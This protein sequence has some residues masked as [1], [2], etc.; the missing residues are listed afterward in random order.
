[1]PVSYTHLEDYN[2]INQGMDDAVN[3]VHI[4]IIE[5]GLETLN[6]FPGRFSDFGRR[7]LIAVSYT[8]LDVYK[9][10]VRHAASG[11]L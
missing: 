5:D 10:Q 3:F 9:R 6:G 11:G 8:H 7:D 1:M 2:F 4:P